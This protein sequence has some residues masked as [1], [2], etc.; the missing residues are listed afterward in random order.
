MA[1]SEELPQDFA[2]LIALLAWFPLLLLHIMPNIYW[3]G[4]NAEQKTSS[5][6]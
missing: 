5:L 1:E 6:S 2:L 3:V 4:K